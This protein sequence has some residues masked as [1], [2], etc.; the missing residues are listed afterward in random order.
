[1]K[2]AT[3]LTN[4]EWKRIGIQKYEQVLKKR[5]DRARLG[6]DPITVKESS[7]NSSPPKT[8]DFNQ[9]RTKDTPLPKPAKE[10]RGC[11]RDLIGITP[12]ETNKKQKEKKPT[13][14]PKLSVDS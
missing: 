10:A 14:D 2:F 7:L 4:N 9:C 11:S 1:M 8:D 5:S 13:R 12:N 3:E 6:L